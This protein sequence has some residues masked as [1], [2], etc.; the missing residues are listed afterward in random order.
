MK[1]NSPKPVEIPGF[2]NIAISGRIGTGK[3]TLA[4]H[5]A[6]SLGWKLL[7][8]GKIFRKYAKDYGFHITEKEKIPDDFDRA[9]EEKTRQIFLNEKHYVIQT[10]LAGFLAQGIEGVYKILVVCEDENGKD[11]SSVRVDRLMNR[12]LISAREAKNELRQREENH[13]KKFRKLYVPNDPKWVYWKKEYFDLIVNTFSLNQ[14]E[15]LEYVLKH[16]KKDV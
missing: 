14:K 15:A 3:S 13:L 2:R 5:L 9:F 16:I 4:E 12:D 6:A 8:G 10:H 11:K 7:D 1:N